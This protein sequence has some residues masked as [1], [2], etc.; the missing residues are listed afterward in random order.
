MLLIVLVGL[1]LLWMGVM[2]I[3]GMMGFGGMMYGSRAGSGWWIVGAVLQFLF[4]LL[5]LGGGYL[6]VRRLLNATESS[7]PAIEELRRAYAR[8]DISDEEFET[9]RERLE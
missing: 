3:G 1:P 4:L 5:V 2:G 6:A 8:G 7:D 9:R